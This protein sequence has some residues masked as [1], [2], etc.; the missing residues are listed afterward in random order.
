MSDW[1]R[2]EFAAQQ[3]WQCPICGAVYSPIIMACMNCTG[4]KV[5]NS[6]ES[7]REQWEKIID[8]VLENDSESETIIKARKKLFIGLFDDQKEGK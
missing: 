8:K 5:S 4:W 2:I 3:G 7:G 6:T 1:D